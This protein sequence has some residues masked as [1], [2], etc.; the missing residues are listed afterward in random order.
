M[1]KSLFSPEVRRNPYPVY[2]HLRTSQSVL[3]AEELQ[4]WSV[5]RY[6]EV[7]MVLS[8]YTRFSSQYGQPNPVPQ[9]PSDQARTG[10]S[11]ITTDPPR[12]TRLRSL[13]NRAFTP[14]QVTALEPR[15]KAIANEL[16]D[17]AVMNGRLDL[18]KE[19]SYPLPV[20]VIAEMLG[21]PAEDRSKFK[22]WSDDVVASADQMIGGDG[23]DSQRSHQEMNAYF[24]EVIADRRE[25]PKDDLVSALIQAEEDHQQ[26]TEEDILA[27]C[28]LLLVAG[29]ETTTNLITNAVRTFLEY[30]EEFEKLRA[31]PDL[32]ASAI[33]EVLRYRSPIQA[34]FRMTKEDV[35]LG[36]QRIPK[37][38]RVI[39]WIGSANRDEEKF[40]HADKFNI[41]RH[42]NQHI[43]FGHGIHFCLGA[44][45]AR[46][47]AK[48]A[49]EALLQ[50]FSEIKRV[51]DAALE[52]TRGFIVHG[53]TSLPLAVK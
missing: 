27:L 12:H 1:L 20:I 18:V 41:M 37:G 38:E 15:I 14:R 52:P 34:M 39:A 51:D 45:L 32:M 16:I 23:G 21:I 7:R 43:A 53:V 8:D 36:E 5:F 11:L 3:Y 29:N 17:G 48:T 13:V 33:E 49:L 9:T 46:L 40:L 6:E 22:H 28:W 4:L 42:P 25:H 26:L 31:N 10:S 47:E 30:P 24:R 2:T 19:V 44:P 35:N 50:R